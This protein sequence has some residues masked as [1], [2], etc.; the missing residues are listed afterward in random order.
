[1]ATCIDAKVIDSVHDFKPIVVGT[2]PM[3]RSSTF[4]P[5]TFRP[6]LQQRH[7]DDDTKALKLWGVAGHADPSWFSPG[8]RGMFL[9][10]ADIEVLRQCKAQ[11][12]MN[13]VDKKFLCRLVNEGLVI[14]HKGSGDRGWYIGMGNV[15]GS[16]AVAWP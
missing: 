5:S 10:F 1:M 15:E 16:L 13:S 14:Q 6:R 3:A 9:P 2:E 11:H 8:S 4:E 12:K 7:L